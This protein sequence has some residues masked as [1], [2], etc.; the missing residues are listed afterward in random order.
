EEEYKNSPEPNRVA[1]GIS[2]FLLSEIDPFCL[3]KE[4]RAAFEKGIELEEANMAFALLYPQEREEYLAEACRLSPG[5]FACFDNAQA[6]SL[7]RKTYQILWQARDAFHDGQY[8]AS[9]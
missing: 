4:A 7:H 3:E 2:L 6:K 8:E 5:S 9:L 1:F